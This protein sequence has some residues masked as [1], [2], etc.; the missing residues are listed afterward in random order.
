MHG[1]TL[2]LTLFFRGIPK[3]KKALAC[4][5]AKAVWHV[6]NGKDFDEA[7]MFG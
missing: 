6:M 1:L 5:L 2:F 3:A 7:L 4:K